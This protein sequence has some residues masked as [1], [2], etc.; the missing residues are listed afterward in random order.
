V[1]TR[2]FAA[3]AKLLPLKSGDNEKCVEQKGKQSEAQME[4]FGAKRS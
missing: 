3:A 1:A 4:L 2:S